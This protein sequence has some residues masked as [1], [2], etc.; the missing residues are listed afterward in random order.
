MRA[1]DVTLADAVRS[2]IQ[3]QHHERAQAKRAKTW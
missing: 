3:R 1:L 2:I